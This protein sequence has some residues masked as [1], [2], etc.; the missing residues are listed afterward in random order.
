MEFFMD[1]LFARIGPTYLATTPSPDIGSSKLEQIV[2]SLC[3]C[4]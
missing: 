1:Y 4:L 3:G 2:P